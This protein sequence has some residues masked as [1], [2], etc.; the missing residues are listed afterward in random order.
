MKYKHGTRRRAKEYEAEILSFWKKNKTFEKSMNN[1][2]ADNS[3]IFYDGPPFLTGTPHH[4]HLL[5]ST[6]KD[7]VARFQTMLGKRV[8]RRWGWDCHGLPA[9]VFVENKL[10]IKAKKK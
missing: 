6:V 1:R 7:A 3:F 2:S 10:G 8:E 4:G 5:I 9:E